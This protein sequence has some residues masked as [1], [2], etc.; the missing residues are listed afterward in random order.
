MNRRSFFGLV[1]AT[2]PCAA[3]AALTHQK[4][5]FPAD[6]FPGGISKSEI[7]ASQRFIQLESDI[8]ATA[9]AERRALSEAITKLANTPLK[10]TFECSEIAG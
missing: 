2:V 6:D 10:V 4:G 9:A 3:T 7:E 8:R 1:A 5:G